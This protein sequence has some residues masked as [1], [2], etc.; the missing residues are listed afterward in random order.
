MSERTDE[1]A[2]VS[3]A[4]VSSHILFRNLGEGPPMNPNH[5]VWPQS[6]SRFH[7]KPQ[8]CKIATLT[9]D[10]RIQG[11]AI[12]R[13]ASVEPVMEGACRDALTG[14]T[15]CNIGP[16][17]IARWTPSTVG[18]MCIR[19]MRSCCEYCLL[20]TSLS[21]TSEV[22]HSSLPTSLL[23]FPGDSIRPV[24]LY[25]IVFTNFRLSLNENHLNH[26]QN[27]ALRPRSC[28]HRCRGRAPHHKGRQ[29]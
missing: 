21:F 24:H 16:H 27:E 17:S 19:V 1:A 29:A 3:K 4:S 15:A 6:S 20:S 18:C 14:V 9:F 12:V 10:L 28:P 25:L 13:Q 22:V 2:D 7:H 23:S 5:Q 11:A 8:G 26:F